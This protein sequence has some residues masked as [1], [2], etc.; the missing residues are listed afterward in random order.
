MTGGRMDDMDDDR[1]NTKRDATPNRMCDA[2]VEDETVEHE[3]AEDG[4]VEHEAAAREAPDAE[5]LE[6]FFRA[7]RDEPGPSAAF[8]SAVLADAAEVSAARVEAKPATSRD[9]R[10]SDERW[11]ARVPAG[12]LWH[13]LSAL[14]GGWR[15]GAALTACALIGFLIGANGYARLTTD[16]FDTTE[17]ASV[18][19][20]V[21]GFYDLAALE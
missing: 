16:A 5:A 6:P 2:A 11:S 21:S 8:L 12:D 17:S 15:G 13:A 18:S 4:N 7:A 20:T 10:W 9:E 19:D 1:P 3:A 14:L